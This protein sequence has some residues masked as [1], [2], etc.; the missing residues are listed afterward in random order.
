MKSTNQQKLEE[1]QAKHGRIAHVEVDGKLFAFRAPSLDEWEDYLESLTKKRRGVC[2][3]ELAQ[4]VLAHPALE[5]LQA[6]FQ[7][8]PGITARIGDAVAELAGN[9]IEVTVKKG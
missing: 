1:L 6:L 9:D 5:D 3:R 8:Q 4:V 7:S 2:H